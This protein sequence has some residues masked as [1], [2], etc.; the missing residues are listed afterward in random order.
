[1]VLRAEEGRIHHE[2]TIDGTR[3]LLDGR[4]FFYQGL[5]F[6][7]AI[8]NPVFNQSGD[9]RLGWLRRFQDNGVNA[10]R[11]WCQWDFSPPRTFVDTAP[12]HTIYAESGEVREDHWR[13]LDA[14]LA[15][16]DNEG[17]VVEVTL[18]SHEKDPNLPTAAREVGARQMTERLRPYRNVILQVWNEDSTDVARHVATI[19]A[20]DPGRIV[21]N[22][23][24][25]SNVLGDDE[26]N[27]TLD[28]LTPHTVRR[29]TERFWEVAPG[30]IADLL[31]RYR[32]PVID[33]EPAR[34]GLQQFGGIPGGT[35]PEQ[36]IE[37]IR[38]VREVGGYHLYHHDM[39]QRSY[40]DPATPPTGIPDPDFSPFHR[41]VFDYLRDHR[42][43]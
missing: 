13:T 20:V 4:P 41:R 2:L 39:F 25:V 12:D 15:A 42:E 38:R 16:A 32:K 23:P 35:T 43:W 1:M 7:N 37:Q 17:M 9:A 34:T 19:K 27:R 8:Y 40:G 18:F 28:L 24:G 10:L 14:I 31:E 3:L 33:D 5:S 6:F 29:Q 30:Q 36:H 26:Q 21:T 22:S 11:V